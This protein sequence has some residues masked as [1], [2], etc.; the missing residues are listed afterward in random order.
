[1]IMEAEGIEA[2]LTHDQH[3]AQAGFH[4]LLR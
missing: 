3:F 1:L 2:A 4:A